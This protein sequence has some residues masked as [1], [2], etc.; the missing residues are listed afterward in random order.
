MKR[1]I[2]ERLYMMRSHKT[3]PAEEDM[4]FDVVIE[5]AITE[6]E[7]NYGQMFDLTEEIEDLKAIIKCQEVQIDDLEE[8]LELYKYPAE[9]PF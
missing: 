7:G 2:L 4:G 1:P 5:D 9:A 8:E 3:Y 6:I